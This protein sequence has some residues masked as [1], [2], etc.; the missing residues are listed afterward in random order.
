[1][2]EETTAIERLQ[3]S[4]R[5]LAFEVREARI[6][7]R[8]AL[9]KHS[10]GDMGLESV[11]GVLA[12]VWVCRCGQ[13]ER[14][15]PRWVPFWQAFRLWTPGRGWPHRSVGAPHMIFLHNDMGD[16]F[17][18]DPYHREG[19]K[20]IESRTRTASPPDGATWAGGSAPRFQAAAKQEG[21]QG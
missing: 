11:N 5:Y 1:M 4:L 7:L 6:K 15:D 2:T 20:Q 19:Q 3:L 14:R 16:E 18:Y 17:T 10:W 8:R 9:C 12:R 21:R 13:V